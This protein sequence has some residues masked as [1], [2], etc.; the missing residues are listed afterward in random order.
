VAIDQA[1]CTSFKAELMTATHDFTLTTGDSFKLALFTSSATLGAATAAYTAP[2]DP[3]A[4]PTSTHEVSTTG[5]N[6]SS[7]GQALTNITPDFTGTTAFVG[8]Q[9]ETFSNVSLTAEGALIYNDDKSDK[10]VMVLDFGEDKTA[11]TCDFT[12]Q[13]PTTD[14]TTA[15]IRIA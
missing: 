15:I 14:A 9:N 7:G 10:A 13:F 12:V 6:Y 4:D 3:A 11:T 5:T 2:A 1:I 8:F